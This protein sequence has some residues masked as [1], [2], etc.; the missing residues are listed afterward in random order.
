M[1]ATKVTR[2]LTV[3][4]TTG[5]K[6]ANA[7]D[8]PSLAELADEAELAQVRAA[9]I[10]AIGYDQRERW[11]DARRQAPVHRKISRDA[12]R[13]LEI[14]GHAIEYLSDEAMLVGAEDDG[15]LAAVRLL[16]AV[17]RR[18]YLACPIVPSWKQRVRNWAQRA[19][20]PW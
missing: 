8:A 5:V 6:E 10:K 1:D 19:G 16:M 17:N 14:L 20:L 3:I 9:I 15:Q 12:G 11:H 18:I 7:E 2:H 13:A 4:D